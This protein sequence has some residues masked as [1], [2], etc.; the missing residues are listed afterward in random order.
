[1]VYMYTIMGSTLDEKDHLI[2]DV[3]REDASL[4]IA[5]IAAQTGLPSTTV[6]NRI[7]K[8]RENKII[9]NYTIK[10]D[11]SRIS[12]EIIAYILIKVY[13]ANQREIV[14]RL[15]KRQDVEEASIVTGDT[16]IIMKLRVHSIGDLDKFIIDDLRNIPGIQASK[17]IISLETYEK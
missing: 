16:D 10:L 2:I 5:K 13:Q 15:M 9:K 3:L 17:T 14:Q 6:H 11:K 8:L 1:M 7:K 4:S 12:G